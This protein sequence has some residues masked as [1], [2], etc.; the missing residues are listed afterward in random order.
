MQLE[1]SIFAQ[2]DREAIF[3]YIEVLH[4]AQMWPEELP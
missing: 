4:S 3:D 1:W 2:A